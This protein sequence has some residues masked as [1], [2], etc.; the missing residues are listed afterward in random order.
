MLALFGLLL[1]LQAR[2]RGREVAY[3]LAVRM[4][5]SKRDHRRSVVAELAGLL[6]SAFALG[7]ALAVVAA[8]LVHAHIAEIPGPLG[9]RLA[10]PARP[11]LLSAAALV[12]ASFAGAW[13]VQRRAERTNVA[14][15]MRLAG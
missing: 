13:A 4:G 8:V 2:Q 15:A 3:A 1:Y 12:L 6:G 5:L 9:A 10:I 11:L 7:S 14:E